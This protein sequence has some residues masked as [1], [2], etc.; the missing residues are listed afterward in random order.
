MAAIF[1]KANRKRAKLRLGISGP[2]GSGKTF[3]SLL[4]ARG[5]G[6]K[7]AM[8][9]T[10]HRSGE[11]YD[12][13]TNYDV[14]TIEAP[15]TP[16]KYTEA[17]KAAESAGY[18][19]IIIDSLSH[20][21]AGEGGLLDLQG[22]IVD[23]GKG[24][25]YTAWRFVTP[26]HNALVEAMLQSKCHIIATMRSK[27]AYALQQNGNK[28]EVV[29]VGME[30]I[31]RD[32][33][34]YEFTICFN[35][36]IDHTASASKDRTRLFDGQFFKITPETGTKLKTWLEGPEAQAETSASVTGEKKAEPPKAEESGLPN[37]TTTEQ[38]QTHNTEQVNVQPPAKK[39]ANPEERKTKIEALT[40]DIYNILKTCTSVEELKEKYNQVKVK[41]TDLDEEA[42][43]IINAYTSSLKKS[44]EVREK[45][46]QKKK[47]A[48]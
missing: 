13:I 28:S 2:S 47:K 29:K 25:S 44:I 39:D 35:I 7:I 12:D 19:T 41:F 22:K 4:I 18:G 38:P 33:T 37:E 32:G 6:E 30:P 5:L 20:A 42:V 26:K 27:M 21:W 17:I 46:A 31:Q 24:N 43:K 8:I 34:E 9:D 10:E 45:D 15:F 48:A 1:T 16:D 40:K 23:S 36:A 14:C 11:L 3:S